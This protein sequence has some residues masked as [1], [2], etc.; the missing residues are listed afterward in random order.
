M[1]TQL[2][3]LE[4]LYEAYHRQALGVAYRLMGDMSDAEDVVQDAFL[5]VWRALDTYDPDRGSVR[6][7]LLS[8]VRNRALDVLRS[9]R[10]HPTT[11]LD[12]DLFLPDE[13]DV[14]RIAQARVD[15]RRARTA[16]SELPAEQR[17][18]I[19]MAYLA[20]LSHSEIATRTEQPL[21]T[22]KGRV[23]LGLQR[24]RVMLETPQPVA[25]AH[26]G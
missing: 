12:L 23:R 22:I 3:D 18:T 20:G 26:A 11:S 10:I 16:L 8:I 7:W 6:T 2:A 17:K 15:G 5:A 9:R 1:A 4:A 21:G 14:A 24:L 13:T 19:E 25:V